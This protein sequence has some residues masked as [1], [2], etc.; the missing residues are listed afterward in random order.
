MLVNLTE[1]RLELLFAVRCVPGNSL[2]S[3]LRSCRGAVLISWPCRSRA[4]DSPASVGPRGEHSGARTR[5]PSS[6]CPSSI[7]YYPLLSTSIHCTSWWSR[8]VCRIQL[9]L[10]REIKGG[11]WAKKQYDTACDVL[12]DPPLWLTRW[13]L[14][15]GPTLWA[16]N[17][18]AKKWDPTCL[19]FRA[20][21]GVK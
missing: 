8:N 6:Q 7:L 19:P 18:M 2:Q 10:H 15:A 21:E 12:Q 11:F 1:P 16:L 3:L 5:S 4:W 9:H 20:T 17:P 14:Q 13:G